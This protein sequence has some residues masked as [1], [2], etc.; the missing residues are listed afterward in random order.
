MRD[1]ELTKEGAFPEKTEED[2]KKDAETQAKE[3]ANKGEVIGK[4]E[5]KPAEEKEVKR[6]PSF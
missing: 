6:G 1:G 2:D 5:E 4:E 3:N